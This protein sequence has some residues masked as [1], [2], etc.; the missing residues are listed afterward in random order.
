LAAI[1][2]E[3]KKGRRLFVGTANID[4]PRLVIWDMGAIATMAAGGDPKAKALFRKVLLA[5]ASIPVTFPPVFFDVEADGQKYTEM[6]VDGGTLT[7]VFFI[8]G[9][10][11]GMRDTVKRLGLDTEKIEAQLYVIRNGRAIPP[12]KVVKDQIGAIAERAI[13]ALSDAQA[14]GDVY[15]LY[16]VTEARGNGFNLAYIPD[17]EISNRKEFFDPQAMRKLFERGYRDAVD[18]HAW[19]STPP[20]WEKMTATKGE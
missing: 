3:H 2:R 19:R 11:H 4:A 12:Y 8:Y 9:L 6:H 18:R 20:G 5:S 1:A 14:V 17:D 13:D 16:A 7:Q 15:R 10:T